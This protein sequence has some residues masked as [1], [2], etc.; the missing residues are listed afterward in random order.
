MVQIN[1]DFNLEDQQSEFQPMPAGQYMGKISN[2]DDVQLTESSN[3]N[4]MIKVQWTVTEGEYE[5]RKLFDNVPLTAKAGFKVK[6]YAEVIGLEEG[7]ELDTDDFVGAEALLKVTQREY[8][9]E[10]RNNIDKVTPAA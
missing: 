4:P 10:P 5:G 2:P 6:Q 1:L 8:Q 3:G 9:G 7:A